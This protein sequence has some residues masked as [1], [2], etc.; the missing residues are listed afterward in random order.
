MRTS[1]PLRFA[2][3]A[4]ILFALS[5]CDTP[6]DPVES[7]SRA[8][9]KE[10]NRCTGSGSGPDDITG[11]FITRCLLWATQDPTVKDVYTVCG[12]DGRARCCKK[13]K[14]GGSLCVW[15]PPARPDT[16]DDGEPTLPGADRL[17]GYD[18]GPLLPRQSLPGGDT[19]AP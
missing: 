12:S 15:N 8:Q 2:A 9:I 14:D 4:I 19:L 10:E 1:A 7:L 18:Q 17:E 3:P 6:P 5:S 16:Q 11:E 13:F